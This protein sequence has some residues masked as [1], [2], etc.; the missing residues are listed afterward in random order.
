MNRRVAVAL[1][2]NYCKCPECVVTTGIMIERVLSSLHKEIDDALWQTG[3]EGAWNSAL[4]AVHDM[5][6]DND[7]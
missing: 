7:D 6:E 2:D 5:I 3:V 1:G 4:L